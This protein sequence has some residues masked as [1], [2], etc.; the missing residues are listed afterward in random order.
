MVQT[1]NAGRAFLLCAAAKGVADGTETAG[2]L[3]IPGYSRRDE[4]ALSG[5]CYIR[6]FEHSWTEMAMPQTSSGHDPDGAAEL[7]PER[8]RLDAL[9]RLRVLDTPPEEAFDRVTRLA[10]RL[11]DAPISLVSLV[12]EQRQ[13]FK[14]NYGLSVCQTDRD[15]AFCA[16]T[17]RRSE[18]FVV[19][20]TWADPR[21]RSN[22]LVTGDT[23]I[24]FYAGA[25]L[26][27]AGGHA[28]GTLCILDH[29][30][31]PDF[32]DEQKRLLID[33]AEMV[34]ERL[35]VR[36]VVQALHEEVEAHRR[37]EEALR[38]SLADRDALL[39]EIH[40][41]VKNN[42]QAIASIIQVE[43]VRMGQKTPARAVMDRIGE[44]IAVMFRIHQTLYTT[45]E[46][47]RVDVGE[48]ICEVAARQLGLHGLEQA[49][50][51]DAR[52]A[53]V[54]LDSDTALRVGLIA[55]ELI[56]NSLRHGFAPDRRGVLYIGLENTGPS[57]FRLVIQD[58][59]DAAQGGEDGVGLMLVRALA[60]QIEA[61]FETGPVQG[62]WRSMLDAP[63]Q[64]GTSCR[65]DVPVPQA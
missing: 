45:E 18:P 42:L 43:A 12:D 8:D 47:D 39:R 2:H 50:E 37:T 1:S 36:C 32:G 38:G 26:L 29:V 55:N 22:P 61:T 19:E 48:Q 7:T 56:D 59:G 34:V 52:C 31:H 33:L 17:I 65:P 28:V 49:V 16:Y 57:G 63:K 6:C 13:W 58:N 4:R 3:F 9:D 20:D 51:V 21:F 10:A 40:H 46:L 35:E 60:N 23:N 30:P 62:G 5:W 54:W 41:R 64:P 24:R 15:I 27:T 11:L 53:R 14:S 44:R 25:P